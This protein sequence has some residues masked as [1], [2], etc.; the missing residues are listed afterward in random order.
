[1]HFPQTSTSTMDMACA[2]D[3]FQSILMNLLGDVDHAIP[4]ID[5]NI[6]IIQLFGETKGDHSK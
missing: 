3:M 2:P 6:I 5:T 1:M 4:Y